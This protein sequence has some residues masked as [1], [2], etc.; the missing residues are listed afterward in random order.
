MRYGTLVDVPAHDI[1]IAC[2][3]VGLAEQV[4]QAHALPALELGA[5]QGFP[6]PDDGET[7]ISLRRDASN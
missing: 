5:L 4:H 7:E 2:K 6:G 3:G 1:I